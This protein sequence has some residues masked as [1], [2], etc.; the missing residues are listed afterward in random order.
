MRK[1]YQTAKGIPVNLDDM[2][3][4][5]KDSIALGNLGGANNVNARGDV[6]GKAGGIVVKREEI[7]A[8]YYAEALP[9]RT[10]LPLSHTT[11]EEIGETFLTPSEAMARVQEIAENI[12][13]KKT[14]KKGTANA[15]KSK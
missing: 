8:Q 12:P 13:K 11:S 14:T 1:Q 7:V 9:E 2:V 4:A 15:N 5:G 10:E 3:T 6:L